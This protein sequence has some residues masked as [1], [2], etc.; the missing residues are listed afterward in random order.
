M[1]KTFNLLFHIL[2]SKMK[3]GKAPI[4]LRITIDKKRVEIAIKRTIEPDKW[5][6]HRGYASGS[7]DSVKSLNA[8]IDIVRSKIYENHKN[9][10]QDDK[11]ITAIALKNAFLGISSKQKTLLE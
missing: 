6:I 4:Y 10:L 5:N 2:L 7:S 9:L 8:Y 1:I 11:P 3:G